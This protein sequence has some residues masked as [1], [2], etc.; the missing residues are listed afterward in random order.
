MEKSLQNPS[1]FC[2]LVRREGDRKLSLVA[3]ETEPHKLQERQLKEGTAG[4][5]T[6][7]L[8][9]VVSDKG[10]GIIRGLTKEEENVLHK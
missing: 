10:F 1:E 3:A 5:K 7:L 9:A 6:M 2:I 8:H 4:Y